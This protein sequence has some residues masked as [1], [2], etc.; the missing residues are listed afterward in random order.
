MTTAR[1]LHRKYGSNSTFIMAADLG[2]MP[3][4]VGQGFEDLVPVIRDEM[5][6]LRLRAVNLRN[7]KFSL[8]N[9]GRIKDS[10]T[11][12]APPKKFH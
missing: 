5:M 12:I 4:P 2:M 1:Y 3:F 11:T 6:A 9:H 7:G 10:N 8:G